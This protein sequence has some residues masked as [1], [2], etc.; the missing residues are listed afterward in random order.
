MSDEVSLIC[1][2][3]TI[4]FSNKLVSLKIRTGKKLVDIEVDIFNI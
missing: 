4:T 2:H 1:P 3:L